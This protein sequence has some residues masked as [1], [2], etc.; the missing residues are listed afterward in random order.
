MPSWKQSFRIWRSRNEPEVGCLFF[1]LRFAVIFIIIFV[2]A[3]V[4]DPRRKPDIVPSGIELN[5]E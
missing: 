4:L 5:E 3:C 1:C 2:G